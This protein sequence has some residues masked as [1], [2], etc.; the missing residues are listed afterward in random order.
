[1]PSLSEAVAN[2][3]S[4]STASMAISS[5][6]EMTRHKGT[7]DAGAFQALVA[8]TAPKLLRVAARI[9]GDI[10]EA[11]DVLQ[12]AYL[13]AFDA[14]A[15][16]RF[17]E[18]C[19]VETWMYR[20]V[21]N[22]ALDALRARKRRRTQADGDVGDSDA[23]VNDEPRLLARRALVELDRWLA[24]LPNEQRT[25]I[26]LKELEGLSSNEVAAIMKCS[27][28]AVEQRLVRART[29]LRQ[30]IENGGD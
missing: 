19:A 9:L 17:D 25:A 16:G 23:S 6:T 12:E 13:R 20:I 27:V 18:K 21:A 5:S 4:D 14:L 1:M 2:V 30:R 10:D 8:A 29:A 22:A 11:E 7:A 3:S 26:V 28:G 15:A 24:A